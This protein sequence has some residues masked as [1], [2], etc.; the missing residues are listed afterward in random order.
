MASSSAPVHPA[1]YLTLFLVL[2][3]GVYLLVF[4]T[5]DKKAEPK[6]GIDLQ[7]GTRI[8]LTARTV[9]GSD[10]TREQMQQARTIME[11]RVNG[12]GVVGAQVQIDGANQLVVTVPGN[13]DLSGLTRTAQLNIRPVV[14][15]SSG[16]P[17]VM[18]PAGYTPPQASTATTPS[19][20]TP[21]T[22]APR[23]PAMACCLIWRS[24]SSSSTALPRR[25]RS[26]ADTTV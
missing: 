15:D 4:L 7:G 2:L 1:R 14:A 25:T 17:I 16:N 24:R 6:L 9:D 13:E 26:S 3:I 20:A 21:A 10:P 19:T 11:G 8:T 12:S 23:A 18:Y 5:G 22:S